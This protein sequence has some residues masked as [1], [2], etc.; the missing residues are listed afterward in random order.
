[1]ALICVLIEKC[2][3]MNLNKTE[4]ASLVRTL[5]EFKEILLDESQTRSSESP[6]VLSDI[7]KWN[8]ND[9]APLL[10]EQRTIW[11]WILNMCQ[12]CKSSYVIDLTWHLEL[13]WYGAC[14]WAARIG[15][16]VLRFAR[17]SGR[18]ESTLNQYFHDDILRNHQPGCNVANAAMCR[19]N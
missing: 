6:K 11:G 17:K 8:M 13:F 5:V 14:F 2:W 10:K 12:I 4:M 9:S 3:K 15:P 16:W 18:D 1:M 7:S 19:G